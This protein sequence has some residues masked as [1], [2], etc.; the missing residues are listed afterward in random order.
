M[1]SVSVGCGL[2]AVVQ[3]HEWPLNVAPE[4]MASALDGTS[5]GSHLLIEQFRR[6]VTLALAPRQS[7]S[8]QPTSTDERLALYCL[9]NSVL[10]DLERETERTSPDGISFSFHPISSRQRAC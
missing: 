5:F 9:L 3:L 10:N 4:Y 2:P 7:H 1:H 6:R 8:T